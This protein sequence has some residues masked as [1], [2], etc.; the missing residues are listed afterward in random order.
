MPRLA[1]KLFVRRC[2]IRDQRPAEPAEQLALLNV[3]QTA[4]RGVS[5][6]R[7]CANLA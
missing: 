1:R 2:E 4:G 3:P 5:Q 6:P 7:A